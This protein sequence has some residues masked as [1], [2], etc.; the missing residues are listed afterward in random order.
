MS[1]LTLQA[2]QQDRRGG[3]REGTRDEDQAVDRRRARRRRPRE[4]PSARGRRQHVPHR[5]RHR[6][7]VGVDRHGR[8][9][10]HLTQRAKDMP[11]FFG[12]L[13]ATGQGKFLP[14]TGAVLIKDAQGGARRRRRER[15]HRRRGRGDLHRRQSRRQGWFPADGSSIVPPPQPEGSM[16]EPAERLKSVKVSASAAMTR[17]VRELR[18][19]GV[20]IVGLSSGDPTQVAGERH[21]GWRTRPRWPARPSTRRRTASCRSRRRCR[22]IEARQ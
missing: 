14:Q 8:R 19:Q 10:A 9:L 18:A 5:H 15:R 21:R 12:A 6:Q 16:F 13:A 7:G 11:A 3:A 22:R 2:G 4:E 20:K 1:R 17:K